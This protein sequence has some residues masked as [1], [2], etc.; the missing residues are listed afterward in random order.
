MCMVFNNVAVWG[1]GLASRSKKADVSAYFMY[2]L[3]YVFMMV[4]MCV[5]CDAIV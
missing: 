3:L 5:C 1:C 4:T 2:L